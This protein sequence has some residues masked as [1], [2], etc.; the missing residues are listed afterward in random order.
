MAVAAVV[1]PEDLGDV[2][3]AAV[4]SVGGEDVRCASV[5]QLVEELGGAFDRQLVVVHRAVE[6]ED[7]AFDLGISLHGGRILPLPGSQKAGRD[8]I[9]DRKT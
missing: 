7:E 4:G 9:E 8:N 1:T 5:A 3:A 2:L 6:V